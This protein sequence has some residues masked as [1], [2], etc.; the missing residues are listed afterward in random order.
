MNRVVITGVGV[1]SPIGC[2]FSD[3]ISAID[4]AYKGLGNLQNID[5]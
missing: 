4:K 2:T 3:C 5:T 1:N